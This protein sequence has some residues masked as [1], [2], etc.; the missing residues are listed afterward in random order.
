MP[1]VEKYHETKRRRVDLAVLREESKTIDAQTRLEHD[2]LSMEQTRLEAEHAH[3]LALA[4]LDV[5]K[6]KV[7][8]GNESRALQLKVKLAELEFNMLK[9]KKGLPLDGE[10]ADGGVDLADAGK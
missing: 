4:R 3:S 5:E 8:G 10:T 1:S 2:R 7:I 6:V 9:L